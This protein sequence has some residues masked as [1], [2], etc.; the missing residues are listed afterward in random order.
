MRWIPLILAIAALIGSLASYYHVVH[1]EIGPSG[2]TKIWEESTRKHPIVATSCRLEEFEEMERRLFGKENPTILDAVKVVIEKEGGKVREFINNYGKICFYAIAH[3][4]RNC[5]VDICA[6]LLARPLVNFVFSYSDHNFSIKINEELER[7]YHYRKVTDEELRLLNAYNFSEYDKH[8]FI[9]AESKDSV[10]LYGFGWENKP[11]FLDGFAAY[12]GI[13]VRIAYENG[14]MLSA[15][16]D[17]AVIISS[18]KIIATPIIVQS[19]KMSAIPTVQEPVRYNLSE[20]DILRNLLQD[21][22]IRNLAEQKDLLIL[23][24]EPKIRFGIEMMYYINVKDLQRP[25]E[26]LKVYTYSPLEGLSKCGFRVLSS[27]TCE[28][29]SEEDAIKYNISLSAK[30]KIYVKCKINNE[31]YSVTGI[32]WN[33]SENIYGFEISKAEYVRSVKTNSGWFLSRSKAWLVKRY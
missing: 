18:P 19:P 20:E 1:I 2:E 10:L 7:E 31:V 16:V 15:S 4:L 11:I 32:G 27:A 12:K 33:E 9:A 8:F 30:N 25:D 13:Q 21:E 6:H 22:E 5:S 28:L 14:K 23:I 3:N 29:I 26:I 24:S 17:H